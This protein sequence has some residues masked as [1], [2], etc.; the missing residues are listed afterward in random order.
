MKPILFDNKMVQAILEGIKKETRRPIKPQPTGEPQFEYEGH[1]GFFDADG[2]RLNPPYKLGELLYVREAW[3]KED[4]RIYYRADGY[5]DLRMHNEEDIKWRPSIH[6]PKE[7]ARIFLEVDYIAMQKISQVTE[8]MA[9]DEGF[10]GA[11]VMNYDFTEEYYTTARATFR[12]KWQEHYSKGPYSL[13]ADPWVWV[14]GFKYLSK[15]G[16]YKEAERS[17]RRM[18]K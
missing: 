6:M 3:L 13:S 9:E 14:I 16:S 1:I 4:D 12:K 18:R 7:Y 5:P 11:W 10:Y 17:E 8:I 15:L 2:R